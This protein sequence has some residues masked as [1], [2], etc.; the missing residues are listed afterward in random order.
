MCA[1]TVLGSK[2]TA[3]LKMFSSDDTTLTYDNLSYVRDR[4]RKY[5]HR[6]K[7]RPPQRKNKNG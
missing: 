2:D 7:G 4:I 3:Y 6:K 5:T 1:P